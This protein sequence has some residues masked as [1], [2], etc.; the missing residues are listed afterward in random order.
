[1]SEKQGRQ[2][3]DV[4]EAMIDAGVREI[5]ACR[6]ACADEATVRSIYIAMRAAHRAG[7]SRASVS[8]QGQSMNRR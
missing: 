5:E 1:M 4:T 6:G 8:Y 2:A 3:D 7:L